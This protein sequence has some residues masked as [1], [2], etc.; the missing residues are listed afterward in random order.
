MDTKI[1]ITCYRGC[2]EYDCSVAVNFWNKCPW[3]GYYVT[4]CNL[5]G[6]DKKAAKSI[7][8]HINRKHYMEKEHKEPINI[9]YEKLTVTEIIK[10]WLKEHGYDGLCDPKNECGCGLDYLGVCTSFI[11]NCKPAYRHPDPEGY[12][13]TKTDT[14]YI[15]TTEK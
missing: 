15:Y 6:G 11:G 7:K 9:N 2:E 14:Y 1:D 13:D 4:Y 3:C 8:E 5:H 10:G 12:Y